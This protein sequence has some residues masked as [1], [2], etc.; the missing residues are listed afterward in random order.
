[1]RVLA[2]LWCLLPLAILAI[3][4]ASH[5]DR[6]HYDCGPDDSTRCVWV[7]Q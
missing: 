7:N 4:L 1:M 2:F 5:P 6:A 3:I